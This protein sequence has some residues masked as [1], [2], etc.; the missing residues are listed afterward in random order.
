MTPTTVH[1]KMT[2]IIYATIGIPLSISMYNYASDLVTS[3]TRNTII[4]FEKKLFK[5]TRTKHLDGK[6]LFLSFLIFI[7]F[8]ISLVYFNTLDNHGNLSVIDSTYYWFQTLTTIGYGDVYPEFEHNDFTE[9]LLRISYM[10]GLG[11]VASLISSIST[12]LHDINQRN[13][14]KLVLLTRKRRRSWKLD[15]NITLHT[16]QSDTFHRGAD[17]CS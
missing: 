9:T 2:T 17:M 5:K 6:T 1:G 8:F 11:M 12:F 7:L 14:N 15:N 10:F 16:F 13:A 3:A 4:F